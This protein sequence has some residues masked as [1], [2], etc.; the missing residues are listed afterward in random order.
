M[1]I[2]KGGLYDLCSQE[3]KSCSTSLHIPREAENAAFHN[4]EEGLEI[5]RLEMMKT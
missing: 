3:N 5:P 2:Q 4:K 1:M